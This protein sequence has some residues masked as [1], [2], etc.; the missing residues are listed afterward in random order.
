MLLAI[1]LLLAGCGSQPT[2]TP[3]ALYTADDVLN[4][5][6]N[7]GVSVVSP[8]RDMTAGRDA[9]S[10]FI[11]RYTFIINI[12]DIAPNGGQLL[13]FDNAAAM[14]EWRQYIERLRGSSATRREVVYVYEKGNVML[15]VN[16]NLTNAEAEAYRDALMAMP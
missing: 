8:E 10:G 11:D 14:D 15:Q 6:T 3:F 7:A 16:A 5:L 4:A 2:P 9:P 1:G 12:R 13:V